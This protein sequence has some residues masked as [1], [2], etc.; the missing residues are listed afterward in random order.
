[1]SRGATSR[2]VAEG[3]LLMVTIIWGG[4]FAATSLLLESGLMPVNLVL[5]R[6]GVALVAVIPFLLFSGTRR[7]DRRTLGA[8]VILGLLLYAGYIF[9]TLGLVETTSSRS[10]F[11]TA[12]YVVMTPMLQPL[13]GRGR[14]SL[15]VWF[16]VLLIIIGLWMLTGSGSDAGGIN[17]GDILTLFCAFF[18]AL[19]IVVLDRVGSDVDVIGLTGVQ[20]AVVASCALIHTALLGQWGYPEGSDAWTLL[21]GLAIFGTVV[22]TWGQTRFQP[23]TT[24][25]RAAII[26]TMESVF[27]ALIGVLILREELTG[28]GAVG[29]GLIVLGLLLVE[30]PLSRIRQRPAS[31]KDDSSGKNDYRGGNQNADEAEGQT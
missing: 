24:P 8:G 7:F 5:W 4:T 6:F 29:G 22:T 16:S 19:F 27:A 30:L 18:F 23:L 20:V 11:I 31:E 28:L 15:Q 26:Y 9:Q 13:F 12:L 2:P 10:G 3:I 17:V 14:P 25:S 21:L 1:M